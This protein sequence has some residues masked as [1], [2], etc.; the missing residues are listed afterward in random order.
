MF[1]IVI[2][3]LAWSPLIGALQNW[4][5]PRPMAYALFFLVM[6]LMV[7]TT[8]ISSVITWYDKDSPWKEIAIQIMILLLALLMTI[9]P[10]F[11]LPMLGFRFGK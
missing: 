10:F 1:L 11:I 3:A 7:P 2:G 8:L 6:Y 9:G 5:T 4:Q